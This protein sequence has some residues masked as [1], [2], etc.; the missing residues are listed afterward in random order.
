MAVLN[1]PLSSKTVAKSCSEIVQRK[2]TRCG[3]G[4][5]LTVS[6]VRVLIAI[7]I[8]IK[9]DM[10]RDLDG[11]TDQNHA[12]QSTP[13]LDWRDTELRSKLPLVGNRDLDDQSGSR[14]SLRIASAL[15]DT[16]RSDGKNS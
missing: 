14:S 11:D 13:N 3:S 6:T 5:S 16:F 12:G 8:A 9:I 4:S 2:K 7:L 15:P 10:P 1:R